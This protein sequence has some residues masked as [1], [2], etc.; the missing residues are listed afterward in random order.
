MLTRT[1]A[2]CLGLFLLATATL[3]E[4]VPITRLA[5]VTFKVADLEKA[6]QFYTGVLGLEEAFGR[7]D[8]GGAIKSAFF[9][10]NDDQ[11]LEFLSGGVEGFH[12]EHISFLT[13]DLK[14]AAALLKQRGI[15]PGKIATSADGN[16]YF[17]IRDPDGTE[18][19]L[20][21]Y[22]PGSLQSEHRG[23]A[24]GARRVS[25]HL[26]HAGLPS[27][28]E[29]ASLEFYGGKLGF[30]EFLRGGPKPGEIRWINL[31]MPGTPGDIT[32]LLIAASDPPQNR[33]HI[34][35]EVPDIQRAYKELLDHGAPNRFKPFPAQNNRWIMF[36]RDPN[37]VLIEFMGEAATPSKGR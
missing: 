36:L 11:Y 28:N 30:H 31:S 2:A 32:E 19:H 3:A 24:L 5:G 1:A 20:V 23:K 18:I 27:D 15:K 10:V 17:A 33:R 16:A 9:K 6:R 22:L 29:A 13:P 34:C 26:Q 35:F 8:S 21:R 4:D 14:K 12:L 7:K 37:G 25:D